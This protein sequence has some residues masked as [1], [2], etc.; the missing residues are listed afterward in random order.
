M[1]AARVLPS[2]GSLPKPRIQDHMMSHLGTGVEGLVS[3]SMVFL[4][5][6][7]RAGSEVEPLGLLTSTH[8]EFWGCKCTLSLLCY[9]SSPQSVVFNARISFMQLFISYFPDHD[10]HQIPSCLVE[11]IL[12]FSVFL[13]LSCPQHKMR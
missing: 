1:E 5:H 2:T 7:R 9:G 12:G 3:S 10:C 11:F 4:G 13:S 6:Y 8:M